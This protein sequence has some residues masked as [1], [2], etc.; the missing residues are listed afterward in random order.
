MTSTRSGAKSTA[1]LEWARGRELGYA[2]F[3]FR[4]HGE[5]DGDLGVI[6]MTDLIADTAAVVRHV[7]PCVLIG[8]SMGGL[9]AAWCTALQPTDVVAL[10]L[11]SPAFGYLPEM[12]RQ[13]E[14]YELQ[15]SDKSAITMQSRVLRDAEQ[16]DEGALPEQIAVPVLVVHGD[17]DRTVPAR[18]S[19]TFCREVPHRDKEFWLIQGGSHSLGEDIIAIIGRIERFLDERR[20]L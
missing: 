15:R 12:A 11:L 6:T 17:E 5:S 3:D 4:G 8:S 20:L 19:E 1:I 13:A 2:R 18:L 10:V 9:A 7:G 14:S 16:Y